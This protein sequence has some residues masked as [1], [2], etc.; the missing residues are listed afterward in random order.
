MLRNRRVT[1]LHEKVNG[2]ASKND[3]FSSLKNFHDFVLIGLVKIETESWLKW[4]KL[5]EIDLI[6]ISI[7]LVISI[8]LDWNL[9]YLFYAY[10]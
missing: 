6:E 8:S 5:I 1:R 7:H 10:P 3:D 2:A 9:A 4:L